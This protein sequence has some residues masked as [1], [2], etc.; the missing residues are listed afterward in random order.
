[1]YQG[2]SELESLKCVETL[3]GYGTPRGGS[4]GGDGTTL[5]RHIR[6]YK[7]E[8]RILYLTPHSSLRLSGFLPFQAVDLPQR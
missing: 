7:S 3:G 5:N 6:K 4:A 2:G 8:H 1:M